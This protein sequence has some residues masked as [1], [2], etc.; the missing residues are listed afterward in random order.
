[1]DGDFNAMTAM[2]GPRYIYP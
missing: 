2:V 1:M